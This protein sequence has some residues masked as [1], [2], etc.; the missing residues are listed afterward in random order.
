MLVDCAHYKDGCRQ[1]DAPLPVDEAAALRGDDEGFVWL[2]LHDPSPE[3]LLDVAS[4]FDLPPLAVEDAMHAHQRPKIEDYD[5]GY[6]LVLHTARYIDA[7]EEVEFGEVHVFTGT[8]YV[9]V[10]RHGAASELR[11]ARERLEQHPELLRLGPAAAVWAVMDKVVDDYQPVVEGIENDVEEVEEVV[12]EGTGDQTRRIYALRREL[13]EFY[14]A[15]HPLMTALDVLASRSREG[16]PKVLR[17]HL[18][19]VEDHVRRIEEEVT[20]QRDVLTSIFQANLAV[21][22]LQQNEVVRQISGWAAIIAV[23]TFMASIWGMN[24]KHMPELSW[25]LGYP[26]ALGAMLLCGLVLYRV[27]RRAGWL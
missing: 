1:N 6:F 4:R 24:F 17:N 27:L 3:E 10:V 16:V 5:R 25:R 8:G 19:D 15:V 18:R 26:L 12:F 21:I 9:I 13:A 22:G 2:G 23:P 20:T 7:S 14:R 11:S